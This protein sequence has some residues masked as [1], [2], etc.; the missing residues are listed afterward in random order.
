MG[1]RVEI[2]DLIRTWRT[3]G[4]RSP[5]VVADVVERLR[6][7]GQHRAARIVSRMP[8]RDGVLDDTAADALMVRVHCEIQRLAEELVQGRRVREVLDPVVRRLRAE[9]DGPVRVVDVGCGLGYQLRWLAA[10][11]GWGDAVELVGVDLDASLVAEAARLA[12]VEG[13]GVRF[14]AGDAFRPGVAVTRPGRTVVV[15]SG[16]LH[17]VPGDRLPAFF[18]AQDELGV[19]AFAHWDPKPGTLAVLGGWIFH[20]ARMREPVSRHDGVLSIRRAHTA[21]TLTAAAR[22][23]APAYDVRCTG[24]PGPIEV[25][26]AITGVRR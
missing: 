13:L 9:S 4:G 16:L 7:S 17:H 18:A 21:A 5:V 15:S 8:A 22:A 19:A 2:T 1:D 24:G 10:H 12:D 20:R 11:G 6:A 3:D 23:G 14:V 25:V 26:H